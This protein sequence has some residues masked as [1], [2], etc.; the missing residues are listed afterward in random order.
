MTAANGSSAYEFD[1]PPELIAQDPPPE[2]G[3]SRLLLVEPGGGVGGEVRLSPAAGP[4]AGRAIC[5]C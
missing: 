1:L 5:W 3:D 2:R 4:A